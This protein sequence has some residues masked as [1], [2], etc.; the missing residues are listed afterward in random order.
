MGLCRDYVDMP[1]GARVRMMSGKDNI[2]ITART[3]FLYILPDRDP[4][5]H[6]KALL[7]HTRIH[8]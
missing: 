7:K 2:I 1:E 4:W 8:Y 5:M 6:T 3:N